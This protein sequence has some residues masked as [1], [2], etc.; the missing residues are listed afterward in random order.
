[1]HAFIKDCLL[2]ERT[3]TMGR[4]RRDLLGRCVGG[5]DQMKYGSVYM[6]DCQCVYVNVCTSMSA[7]LSVSLP[8]CA[9]GSVWRPVRRVEDSEKGRSAVSPCW[10]S[11][12]LMG[13][14]GKTVGGPEPCTIQA[15][16]RR[17]ATT[18]AKHHKVLGNLHAREYH[19][20]L[21]KMGF[22]FCNR[23]CFSKSNI[24]TVAARFSHVLWF[25]TSVPQ[26]SVILL[27]A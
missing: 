12:E 11:R 17:S 15:S 20:H 8:A 24:R 21:P 4:F 26:L 7:C 6:C 22:V 1:M 10:L 2:P 5:G 25:K 19:T 23:S 13:A 9:H 14:G 16:F 3:E 27:V 18:G